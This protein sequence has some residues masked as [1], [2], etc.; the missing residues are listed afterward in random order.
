LG[1]LSELA[2]DDFRNLAEF[3]TEEGDAISLYFQVPTPADKEHREEPILA[4]EKI[5]QK[6]KALQ[7]NSPADREDIARVLDAVA[8]MKGNHRVAKIIFACAAQKFWR[9]YDV[10]GDFGL[11]LDVGRS[12]VLAPLFAEQQKRKR[13]SIA[14]ADR[15]RARLLLL[16][17]HQIIE[18]DPVLEEEEGQEK[19]RTTG[20]RKSVH[21]ERQKEE[22]AR[23]HFTHLTDLLL[24]FYEHGDFDA[25]IVGCRNE[26][27]P[28]IEPALH[29]ELKRV[30]LGKFSVDPGL[31]T[32]EEIAEKAQA[33]IDERDRK[34]EEDLMERIAGSAASDRLGALGLGA[35]VEA[36]EKGEVRTLLFPRTH[37]GTS[38]VVALCSNCGHLEQGESQKCELCGERMR[39]F[40]C[41]EEALLRHAMG[42]SIEMR[43]LNYAKLPPGSG[44]AAWLRFRA[45]RNNSV[46]LA[47]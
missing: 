46:A 40:D 8:G 1:C 28:E 18:Q 27:W 41:P 16:E 7:A 17:A 45:E 25:L 21:L 43:M 26:M 37:N 10:R 13:Y 2:V 14:L 20:A 9:E 5:K 15:N 47:S 42:R 36:L 44:A 33:I 30:L 31:A 38:L 6:L 22:R 19:I 35:V 32:H 12:L 24:H 23:Q 11:R 34:E 29:P 4:K 3:W 39:A